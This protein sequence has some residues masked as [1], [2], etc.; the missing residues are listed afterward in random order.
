MPDPSPILDVGRTLE[1]LETRGVPVV[2]YGSDEVA[3]FYSH[4][5][6]YR[7][8]LR[9]DTPGEAAAIISTQRALGLEGGVLITQPLPPEIALPPDEVAAAVEQAESEAQAAGIHGPASTPF[10][11]ARVAQLTDGRSVRAN[12]EI[13]RRDAL[14]LGRS[15]WPL[16]P[17]ARSGRPSLRTET[18]TSVP[19]EG[20]RPFIAMRRPGHYSRSNGRRVP[21]ACA[22]DG[23]P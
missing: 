15:R 2:G 19:V 1:V 18:G 16:P 8:P 20:C 10:V 6:G 21:C 11:L 12:L 14:S 7:A 5:S 9:V 23:N 3:G 22:L 4:S 13:I 17:V